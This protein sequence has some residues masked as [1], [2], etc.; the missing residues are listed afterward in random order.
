MNK[1]AITRQS[2]WEDRWSQPEAEQLLEALSEHHRKPI[3]WLLEQVHHLDGIEQHLRWYGKAWKW[4]IELTFS[5]VEGN[6]LGVLAYIVPNPETPLVSVP[7]RDETYEEL[8]MRRL[9]KYIR[10]GIR[11]A[12][13]AVELYWAGWTPSNKS[14]AEHLFDL[15][16]RKHRMRRGET[17][18]QQQQQQ[19][20]NESK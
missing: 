18:Q 3:E 20:K 8:P 11:S 10:E 5:D 12:K 14:E 15:L 13:C 17:S 16:K 9:N 19:K 2:V 7:L 6:D 4:T 1:A